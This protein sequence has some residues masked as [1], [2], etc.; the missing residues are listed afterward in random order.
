VA[1]T[2]FD[3]RTDIISAIGYSYDVDGD[4][5]DESCVSFNYP[6][7]EYTG[8]RCY[9]PLFL[10]SEARTGELPNMPFI[11]VTLVDAP[12]RVHN[13]QGDVR[14]DEAYMD[15]NIYAA[16]TDKIYQMKTW[17]PVCKNELVDKIMEKRHTVS[18]C[19]WVEPVDMGREMFE[20]TPTRV[21]FHHVIS[22]YAYEYDSG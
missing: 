19:T 2:A 11:E 5:N 20:Q 12:G 3:P 6:D 13:V 7:G 10:P 4:G 17:M 21:V 15:F 9:V 16:N 8:D 22:V 1:Y 14:V 18:N